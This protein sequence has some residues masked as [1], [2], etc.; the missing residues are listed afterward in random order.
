MHEHTSSPISNESQW[1]FYTIVGREEQVKYVEHV[2]N[3]LV[4]FLVYENKLCD[5][6]CSLCQQ[7]HNAKK[8]TA[9]KTDSTAWLYI[10]YINNNNI[11]IHI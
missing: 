9:W 1:H 10:L 6:E 7:Y 11:I 3:M 2:H 4:N 5:Y 8:P